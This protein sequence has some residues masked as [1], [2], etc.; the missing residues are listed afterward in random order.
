MF[1]QH[2]TSQKHK[3]FHISPL[4]YHTLNGDKLYKILLY[5]IQMVKADTDLVL[6]SQLLLVR[7]ENFVS[8]AL[9]MIP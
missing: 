4:F 3:R 2:L 8:A 6:T 9:R 7:E 1:F 5:H